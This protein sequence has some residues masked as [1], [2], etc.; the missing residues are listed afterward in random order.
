MGY[1]T[2]HAFEDRGI[3]HTSR[4]IQNIH[5]E[6]V[7]RAQYAYNAIKNT[8]GFAENRLLKNRLVRKLTDFYTASM[9]NATQDMLNAVNGAND[10]LRRVVD[11]PLNLS[12]NYLNSII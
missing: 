1:T 8:Y 3:E 9:K 12:A 5:D 11:G 10:M 4:H 6:A 7:R 2:T